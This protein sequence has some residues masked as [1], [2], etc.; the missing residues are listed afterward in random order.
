MKFVI[1]D[2]H[3]CYD[4]LMTL[5]EKLP[6]EAN[7]DNIVFVGDLV[8][9]G[10]DSRK[11]I[12]FI[13][14]GGYDVVL[15]NHEELMIDAVSNY[16]SHN[17]K[18]E[19][20]R[21][22]MRNGG[23]ATLANYQESYGTDYDSLIEDAKWLDNLPNFRIY[24]DEIDDKGRILVVTH[25]VS[26]DFFEDYVTLLTELEGKSINDLSTDEEHQINRINELLVWNRKIPKK[27]SK[28]FFNISGHNI[29]DTFIFDKM[30]ELKVKKENVTPEHILV[31]NELG[32]ACI[33][34]GAFSKMDHYG[35]LNC[36]ETD[37][38]DGNPYRGRMTCISFPKLNV[39]QQ[40][41][42][43]KLDWR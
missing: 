11:I 4:T 38:I 20:D 7:K 9:R 22:W 12:N 26:I 29:I 2:L 30:N 23:R 43:E 19:D 27:G 13:R 34:T 8:D 21:N 15:G 24:E 18:V 36:S 40:C 33:D 1:S 28:V 6:E 32:C 37:K 3:G 35:N 5:L 14:D 41:N 42:I 39:I 10:S 31:D 16:I 17:V 25:A